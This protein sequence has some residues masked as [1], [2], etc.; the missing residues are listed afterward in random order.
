MCSGLIECLLQCTIAYYTCNCC[1]LQLLRASESSNLWQHYENTFYLLAYSRYLWKLNFKYV[2]CD[3]SGRLAINRGYTF[4]IAELMLWKVAASKHKYT[5]KNLWCLGAT[6]A[7]TC[8]C[9]ITLMYLLPHLNNFV[10]MGSQAVP[11]VFVSWFSIGFVNMHLD[12]N[13]CFFSCI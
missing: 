5:G 7:A 10:W 12:N 4:A 8:I 11:S 9:S 6:C 13:S 2:V 1:N 3:K